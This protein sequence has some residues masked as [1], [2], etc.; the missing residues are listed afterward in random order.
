MNTFWAE[1]LSCL[2]GGRVVFARLGRSTLF[3]GSGRSGVDAGPAYHA[4]MDG[5]LELNEVANIAREAAEKHLAG[6]GVTGVVSEPAVDSRG[7][8]ALRITITIHSAEKIARSGDALLDTL[9]EIMTR[10]EEKGDS[11]FPIVDY[12]AEDEPILDDSES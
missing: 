12:A 6:L 2:R 5:M 11:R 7:D 1:N 10:L 4:P 3:R 8:E 9:S